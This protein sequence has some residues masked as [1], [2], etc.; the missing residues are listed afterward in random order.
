MSARSLQFINCRHATVGLLVTN[1][2]GGFRAAMT[3]KQARN[4]AASPKADA[5]ILRKRP[6]PLAQLAEAD[7]R[8]DL[9]YRYWFGLRPEDGLLPSRSKIDNPAFRFLVSDIEIVSI[10]EPNPHSWNFGR[11]AKPGCQRKPSNRQATPFGAWLDVLR[12][13]GRTMRYTGSPLLQEIEFGSPR[14]LFDV[15][16]LPWMSRLMS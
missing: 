15:L 3:A 8:L 1:S 7:V 9:A 12:S 5:L 11:L 16:I 13:D 6:K 2:L 10:R 14:A 4:S